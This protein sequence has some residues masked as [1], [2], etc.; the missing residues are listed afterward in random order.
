MEGRG[1]CEKERKGYEQVCISFFLEEMFIDV[2]Q[3]S[4]FPCANVY[5]MHPCEQMICGSDGKRKDGF[6]N[7]TSHVCCDHVV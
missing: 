4:H 2:H 5:L 1:I 6:P 7:V 3:Y